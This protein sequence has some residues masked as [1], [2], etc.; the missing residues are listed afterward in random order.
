MQSNWFINPSISIESDFESACRRLQ[1]TQFLHKFDT[2][3]VS[4]MLTD[5]LS[6]YSSISLLSAHKHTYTSDFKSL[7]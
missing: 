6:T 4:S 3:V 5:A 2:A 7:T 1:K